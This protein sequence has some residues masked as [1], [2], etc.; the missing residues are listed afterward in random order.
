M[1][2]PKGILG[3]IIAILVV[4]VVVLLGGCGVLWETSSSDTLASD[5]LEFEGTIDEI[6]GCYS[7]FGL[8]FVIHFADGQTLAVWPRDYVLYEGGTY[9][10]TVY[11]NYGDAVWHIESLEKL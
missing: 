5:F 1:M 10:W 4:M 11:R 8:V 3:M 7:E 6:D 2:A 9:R